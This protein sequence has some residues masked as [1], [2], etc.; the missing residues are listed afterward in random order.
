MAAIYAVLRQKTRKNPEKYP[1]LSPITPLLS[2]RHH[3]VERGIKSEH[4]GNHCGALG[5]HVGLSNS[6]RKGFIFRAFTVR[7]TVLS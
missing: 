2:F 4:L 1:L 3:G 6:Y 5:K 7:I